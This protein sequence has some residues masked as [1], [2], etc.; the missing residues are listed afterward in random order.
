M[1]LLDVQDLTVRF[2]TRDGIV[3]AVEG[4]SFS[5]EPGETLGLVGESGSG[6]SVTC[7][8][9]LGLVPCP[10]G[11]IE[12]GRA[13]FAGVDLLSCGE[14]CLRGLRGRRLGMIFQDPMTALNPY[15]TIGTQL[16]ETLT[17]HARLRRQQAWT[18]AEAALREVGIQDA[19]RLARCYPHQLSGGMRQR[20]L[21]AMALIA[22]PAVVIA[23]EPT[24]ALDVTVQAQILE[25]IRAL[26]KARG[27]AMVLITH[28]LGVVAGACDLVA[29]MYAGRV[30]ESG[31]VAD[32]FRQPLHPYTQALCRALP[33]PTARGLDLYSIP[34]QPPRLTQAEP[35]CPFAPR[36]PDAAAL[37]REPVA[38]REHAPGHRTACVRVQRGEL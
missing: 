9:L 33:R 12:G 32:V 7:L 10:P 38:L 30:V 14:R 16:T 29:V 31:P 37:C 15:L 20:V 23:D 34:G 24:T 4:V 27:M 18:Q 8:S 25:L 6:K 11:R 5:L 17:C 36:C 2:H 3:R 26:Q 35:G 19:Q 21:I 13:L 28:N 1:P 22:H